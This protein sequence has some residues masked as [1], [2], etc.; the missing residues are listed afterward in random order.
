MEYQQLV[1][2]P[3]TSIVRTWQQPAPVQQQPAP[4]QQQPAPVQ[5]QPSNPACFVSRLAGELLLSRTDNMNLR[6]MSTQLQQDVGSWRQEYE[7]LL[8]EYWKMSEHNATLLGQVSRLKEQIRATRPK[9]GNNRGRRDDG[10]MSLPVQA[11][12]SDIGSTEQEAVGDE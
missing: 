7:K 1:T 12:S 11:G 9:R 6:H 2:I 5:Q 4:V 8:V 3:E 10:I